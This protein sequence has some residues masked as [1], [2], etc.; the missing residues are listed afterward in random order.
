LSV[1]GLPAGATG[2]VSPNPAT[3]SAT[4]TV[5]TDAATPDGTVSLTITGV[6]GNLTH[7]TTVSLAVSASTITVTA[8]NTAVTWQAHTTQNVTFT[9]DLG[10]GRPVNIDVSR[11]GGVTW[12]LVGTLTTTS[13]TSGSFAWLVTAPSTGQARMRVSSASGT[14]SDMSDVNFTITPSVTVTSPNSA[15][16]WGAGSTRTVTWTHT[17]GVSS[18]VDL[19]FSPDNGATWIPMASGVPNSTAT[20]GTYTGAMPSVVTT[21]GRVRVSWSGDPSDSDLGDGLVTLATPA[22]TVT[23]PNTNVSWTI[24]STRTISWTHNLGTLE[25]VRIELS[26][27]AGATWLV[28]TDNHANSGTTSGSYSWI[29]TGPAT[30]TARIR[31]SWTKNV[32]VQDLSNVNFRVSSLVTITAPNT[33]VTWG[34]GSTRTITWTHSLGAAQTF[35]VD[36]SPDNGSS[37]VPIASGVAAATA[38]TGTL[39]T[40]IPSTVTTQALVRVSPA[41]LPLNGD[42]SNVVFTVAAPTITVTARTR[43]STG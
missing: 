9:H 36:F 24:G 37:W 21:Q 1:S 2:S 15:V 5:T 43:T 6:S 32:A 22:V 19:A 31:T 8:P 39:T 10:V 27:D 16:T 14:A 41:G 35:D 40:A 17:L 34:A 38:T 20:T 30:T 28:L 11:D 42:V 7:T 26:R 29:V 12:A 33:A 3:A 13:A 4:L 18:S 23:A 25:N